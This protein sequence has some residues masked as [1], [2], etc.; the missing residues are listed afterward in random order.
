VVGVQRAKELLFSTREIDAGEARQMGIVLEV[1]PGTRLSERARDMARS[2]AEASPTALS[3]IKNGMNASLGNDLRTM[4]E[5]EATGQGLARSTRYH[6]DAVKRFL[7][8]RPL[9]FQWPQ[10]QE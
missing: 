9:P 3:L 7:D 10:T 2:F 8:K 5:M 4:L 1:H 6:R